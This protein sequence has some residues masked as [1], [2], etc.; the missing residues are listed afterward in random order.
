MFF[1]ALIIALLVWLVASAFP[2]WLRWSCY[3]GAPLVAGLVNGLLL[4]DVTYGLQVGATVMMAYIGLVAI[5]GALPSEMAVAGYLGVAMTMLAKAD[6]SVGLTIA[7]PLGMLGLLAQNARM[8]LNPIVIHRADKYAAEGNT[9]GI[10]LMNLLGSQV[11]PFIVYFIPSFLTVYVG[12]PYLEKIL[13][14]IPPQVLSALQLVGKMMPALG[15]AM[16]MQVLYKR[17]TLPFF[18]IGFVLAAYLGVDITFLAILGGAL[19]FLHLMYTSKG[20][21]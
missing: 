18:V 5:G 11:V 21:N 20:E 2:M 7:V 6:P 14:S 13:A 9:K 1:N 3:F 12:A 17:T 4:G 8:S 16:L 19:G 15:L 10:I